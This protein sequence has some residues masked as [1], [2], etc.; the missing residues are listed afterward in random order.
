MRRLLQVRGV[1]WNGRKHEIEKDGCHGAGDEESDSFQGIGRAWN[2]WIIAHTA[3]RKNR[4]ALLGAGYRG[5]RKLGLW[6]EYQS[7]CA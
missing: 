1:D 3:G 4:P 5:E 6:R 7:V 2:R